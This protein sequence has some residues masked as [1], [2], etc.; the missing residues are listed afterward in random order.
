[1]PRWSVFNLLADRATRLF[2]EA[3]ARLTGRAPAYYATEDQLQAERQ[4]PPSPEE[5]DALGRRHRFEP[6]SRAQTPERR[7]PMGRSGPTSGSAYEREL[8]ARAQRE[9]RQYRRLSR[10]TAQALRDAG[11]GLPRRGG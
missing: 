3:A 7:D 9:L 4:R 8:V 2:E 10:A 6:E 5:Q 11:I 1:M